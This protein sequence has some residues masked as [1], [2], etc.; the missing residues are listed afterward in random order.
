MRRNMGIPAGRNPVFAIDGRRSPTGGGQQRIRSAPMCRQRLHR[1]QCW[2]RTARRPERPL[3]TGA[4]TRRRPGAKPNRVSPI[5]AAARAGFLEVL[6]R[7]TRLQTSLFAVPTITRSDGPR[8]SRSKETSYWRRQGSEQAARV[9]GALRDGAVAR[10]RQPLGTTSAHAPAEGHDGR[11]R[12]HQPDH[13]PGDDEPRQVGVVASLH[14][15]D[16][17]EILGAEPTRHQG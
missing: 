12:H 4:A 9:G 14:G 6:W 3:R 17:V 5:A 8:R 10:M 2:R 16:D 13:D 15:E 7:K 11:Q 1:D